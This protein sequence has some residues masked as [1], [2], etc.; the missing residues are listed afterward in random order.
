MKETSEVDK[1]LLRKIYGMPQFINGKTVYIDLFT[2]KPRSEEE[3][4]AEVKKS[5]EKLKP[6]HRLENGV[7]ILRVL[8]SIVMLFDVCMK[9]AYYGY[10]RFASIEIKNLY[11]LLLLLR[12]MLISALVVYVIW[13]K[14]K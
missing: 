6:F 8:G 4:A 5:R 12:P 3:V 10:S 2:K 11:L 9:V 1:D 13:L 7:I 14:L